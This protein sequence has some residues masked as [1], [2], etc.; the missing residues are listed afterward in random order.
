MPHTLEAVIDKR[1]VVQLLEP[2]QL[3]KTYRALVMILEDETEAVKQ[4]LRPIGLCK[5]EFVVPDDFD[6]PLPS[7]LLDLFEGA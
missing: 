2:I 5:G 1:G 6:D 7:D 3:P 4:A